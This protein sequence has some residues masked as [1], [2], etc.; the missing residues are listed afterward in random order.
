MAS[1]ARH[2]GKSKAVELDETREQK[3]RRRAFAIYLERGSEPGRD[4]EDWL[5]AER[6]LPTD[7]PKKASA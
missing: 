3:I 1:K 7:K 4:L 6:E 5:Q 2:G